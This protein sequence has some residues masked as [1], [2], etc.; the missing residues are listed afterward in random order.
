MTFVAHLD[1]GG[2]ED[3]GKQVHTKIYPE[4]QLIQASEVDE[5]WEK[6]INKKARYRY[7]IDAATF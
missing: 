3:H 5:T 4:V 1:G 6:L 7:V 2:G